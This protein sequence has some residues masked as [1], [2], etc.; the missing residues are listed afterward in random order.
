MGLGMTPEWI[1]AVAS[2]VTMLVI[3]ASAIAALMQLRHMRGSNQIELIANWTEAIEGEQFQRAFAFVRTDLPRILSDEEKLRSLS[4]SPIPPELQPVRTV[5][6]HFES[7]GSFVRRGII[8]SD[9][10]CDL[11]ALVVTLAWDASLPV[12]TLARHIVGND[13][14]WENFEY[15]AAISKRWIDTHPSGSYPNDQPRMPKDD[16]LVSILAERP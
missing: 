16:S 2:I 3:G 5:A 15:M 12:V 8:E 13:A 4:W 1:S 9:V 14:L 7:I 11:W 10:A 6:N